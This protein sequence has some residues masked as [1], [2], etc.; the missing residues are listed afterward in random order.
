MPPDPVPPDPPT[1][2]GP[3]PECTGSGPAPEPVPQEDGNPVDLFTG[4][5]L[6][7]LSGLSVNGLIPIS[8]SLV[9]NPVDAYNNRA[10][11]VGSF[12]FGWASAYDIGFLPFSGPQKR[13]ILPGTT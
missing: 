11:T 9:Y 3:P 2:N 4:Q 10:G 12:G 8:E 5:Q 7:R 13:L 6:P 1:T